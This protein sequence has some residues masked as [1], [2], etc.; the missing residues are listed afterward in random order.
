MG[1]VSFLVLAG[2]GAV[3]CAVLLC[4]VGLFRALE[5]LTLRRDCFHRVRG[6]WIA[7][8]G[9]T[10]RGLE[11]SVRFHDPGVVH[12]LDIYMARTA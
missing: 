1:T 12:W 10:K 11:Q 4:F 9:R 5:A 2:Q 6:A 7:V 8:L 3:A